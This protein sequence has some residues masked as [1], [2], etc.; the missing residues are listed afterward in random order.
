MTNPSPHLTDA[1]AQR[2]VDGALSA[3]EEPAVL[4]HAAAC[5]ECGATVETYR[6]LASALEDLDVPPLPADFTEGVLARIDDRERAL[7]RERRHAVAILG[8]LAAGT[9]AAFAIA[10]AAAWAP[11]VSS[12]AEVLGAAARAAQVGSSFVPHVVGALRLQIIVVA[13]VLALPLLVALARL[14]P[15]QRAEIA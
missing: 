1:Q 2:L 4:R 13:A 9:A 11:L 3:A 15:P 6:L 7:A 12:S 10:G 5:P 14:M 8:V